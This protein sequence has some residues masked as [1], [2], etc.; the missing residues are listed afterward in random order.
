MNKKNIIINTVPINSPAKVA[1]RVIWRN[2]FLLSSGTKSF[3]CADLLFS[4]FKE[5]LDRVLGEPNLGLVFIGIPSIF[6]LAITLLSSSIFPC[7]F[8]LLLS[9]KIST[10]HPLN[11]Y[12]DDIL[13]S[14]LLLIRKLLVSPSYI[15]P[16]IYYILCGIYN[17]LED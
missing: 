4:I 14:V 17:P 11:R 16:Y 12:I 5:S 9:F 13:Q 8:F 6:I 10:S 2:S 3:F 7:S 1:L 15:F